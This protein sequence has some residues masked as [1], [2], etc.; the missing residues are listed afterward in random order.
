MSQPYCGAERGVPQ[1]QPCLC[2]TVGPTSEIGNRGIVSSQPFY[3]SHIQI[4]LP[5]AGSFEKIEMMM[6]MTR[7]EYLG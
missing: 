5:S 1:T 2:E 7:C 3:L 4:F 6:M